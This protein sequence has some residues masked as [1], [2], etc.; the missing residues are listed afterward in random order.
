MIESDSKTSL[1]SLGEQ[2]DEIK[3]RTTYRTNFTI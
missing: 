3:K 2:N 1:E